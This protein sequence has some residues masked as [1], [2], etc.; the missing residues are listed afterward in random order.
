LLADQIN[1][2]Q[3]TL[4]FYVAQFIDG[5]YGKGA[6]RVM[7]IDLDAHQGNGHARDFMNDGNALLLCLQ[8]SSVSQCL[9]T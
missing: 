2:E 7:I 4:A 6:A 3:L 9:F 8:R 5:L 1:L